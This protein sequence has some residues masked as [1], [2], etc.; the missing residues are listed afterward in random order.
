MVTRETV[1]QAL[2]ALV[3][4]AADFQTK[5][6]NIK[7]TPDNTPEIPVLQPAIFMLEDAEHTVIGGRGQPAKRT[8]NVHLFI[9]AKIPDGLTPGIPDGV[10]PGASVINPL[11]DAIEIA[12][13]PSSGIDKAMNVQTLGGLVSHC[14]IEG[15]TIKVPGDRNPDGQ[16]YAAIPLKILVP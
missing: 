2:F 10:T 14:W 7:L 3:S 1:M 11:I 8:W 15:E 12:L 9:Y 13:A 16:C 5:S 4:G 6:R